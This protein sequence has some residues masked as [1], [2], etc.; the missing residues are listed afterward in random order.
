MLFSSISVLDQQLHA[1]VG[2]LVVGRNCDVVDAGVQ[3]VVESS[4]V[5]APGAGRQ[6]IVHR[7]KH[8]DAVL[9]GERPAP[10]ERD[11]LRCQPLQCGQG[12][13]RRCWPPRETIAADA[14][15]AVSRVWYRRRGWQA[16]LL[17]FIVVHLLVLGS[18]GAQQLGGCERREKVDG[19]QAEHGPCERVHGFTS[20]LVLA[21]SKAR[22]SV[23][24]A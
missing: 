12:S 17:V 14:A 9:V 23:V 2:D 19:D 1:I 10:A 11:H 13:G 20:C 18:V 15:L 21:L 6:L 8:S 24:S 7:C 16:G 4:L 3:G 22:N 5:A